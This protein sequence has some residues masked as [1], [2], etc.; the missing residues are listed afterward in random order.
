[1]TII[2]LYDVKYKVFLQFVLIFWKSW[3]LVEKANVI[4]LHEPH[5]ISLH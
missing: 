2:V 1:V 5:V 4:A 3:S